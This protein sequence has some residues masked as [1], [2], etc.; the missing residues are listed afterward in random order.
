MTHE[1]TFPTTDQLAAALEALL[2]QATRALANCDPADRAHWQRQAGAYQD[3]KDDAAAGRFPLAAADG[4]Y[5]VPS[6]STLRLYHV[7]RRGGFW[8]CNCAARVFCRHAAAVGGVEYAL[9]LVEQGLIGERDAGG[10]SHGPIA[11]TPTADGLTLQRGDTAIACRT[12]ED[13]AGAVRALTARLTAA[14]AERW[15]A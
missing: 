2:D 8:R 13:V 10:E 9:D 3:A 12:P 4:A 11:I 1:L 6:H 14:K 15:A 5:L 7:V